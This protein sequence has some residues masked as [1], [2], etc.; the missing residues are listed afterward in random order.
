MTDYYVDGAVGNDANTGLAAGAGNAWAT[1][2]HAA[3][4]IA[5]NDTVWV[6]ASATYNET[7]TTVQG[8]VNQHKKFYGYETTPGD[9]GKATISGAT[10]CVVAT[11]YTTWKNFVFTGASSN[12]VTGS[13]T[14]FQLYINCEFDNPG[15]YGLW[16][17]DYIGVWFC[18]FTGCT[19]AISANLATSVVG[20]TFDTC[21]TGQ[22]GAANAN[23]YRN[24]FKNQAGTGIYDTHGGTYMTFIGNTIVGKS[25]SS[26]CQGPA[27]STTT[28]PGYICAD[29]IFHSMTIGLPFPL[30]TAYY[31]M[32]YTGNNLMY[33]VTK[34]YTYGQ[35][36]GSGNAINI[37]GVT[38]DPLFT[39]LATGDL[40]L[41]ES[42]P[43]LD[44]GLTPLVVDPY[45]GDTIAVT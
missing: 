41:T 26:D 2:Q 43:A 42:S 39:D 10:N 9:D 30:N 19:F 27:M 17:D 4:T 6:K 45:S 44:T 16:L 1:I 34:P 15:Q 18:S 8:G 3:S 11:S 25:G 32:N 24:V 23:W 12:A 22:S 40:T 33:D 28:S 31:P 5:N 29:N 38:G 20:C 13:T 36:I 21:I 14:D 37:N 35:T 7:V